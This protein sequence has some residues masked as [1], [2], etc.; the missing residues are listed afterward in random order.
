MRHCSQ[1]G[2]DLAPTTRTKTRS[3]ESGPE[4]SS[5]VGELCIKEREEKEVNGYEAL[6]DFTKKMVLDLEF[7]EQQFELVENTEFCG[8]ESRAGSRP[9]KG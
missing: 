6:K 2:Q 9:S 8:Q 7:E 3:P 4:G 1:A 5:A